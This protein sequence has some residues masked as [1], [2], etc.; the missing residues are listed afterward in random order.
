[1]SSGLP[2]DEVAE[3]YKSSLEDLVVN[4]RN[5]IGVLTVIAKENT[6]HAMAISRVL[7]NHI[8]TAPPARKL[9]AL[10]VL[11]SIV[12]NVGTPYTLYFQR[13]LYQ[14]FMG[15]YTLVDSNVRK[16]LDEMLKT[17]KEPVPGSLDTRPVFPPESTREIE[18][19]LIKARTAAIQQQARSQSAYPQMRNTNTP[20]N[21]WRNTPPPNSAS[22]MGQPIPGQVASSR[23][24]F[25]GYNSSGYPLQQYPT[26]QPSLQVQYQQPIPSVQQTPTPSSVDL[27]A[28]KQDVDNLVAAARTEFANNIS[29]TGVQQKLKALLDLKTLLDSRPLPEHQLRQIRDQ[30]SMMAPRQQPISRPTPPPMPMPIQS[31]VAPPVP[32]S[33]PSQQPTPQP[34]IPSFI[35]STNLAELLRATANRNQPTPPPQ[36]SS[37]SSALPQ[38][39]QTPPVKQSTPGPTAADNPIIAQLRA[40]GILTASSTPSAPSALPFTP[41]VP[42]QHQQLSFQQTPSTSLGS[43][44]L[45][46]ASIKISRLNLVTSLYEDRPNR[47]TTCGRRF[48]ADPEGKEKKS[49]HLDW[50]FKTNTRLAEAAKRGQS[51]SWYV[52]E[53]EW[54]SSRE[55]EDDSGPPDQPNGDNTASSAKKHEQFIL[56]P[57]DPI[58]RNAPCPI[59]QEKF[60]STWSEELQEFIWKDALKIN[61]RIYHATCYKEATKDKERGTTP[62]GAGRGR[63]ATPDSILGKRKAEDEMIGLSSKVK[64]EPI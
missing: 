29:N 38:I 19:A 59:C 26:P 8:R 10:Y 40:A 33:V 46:T 48:T 34:T 64:V 41:T 56:A 2:S 3:D 27:V 49:R 7:E 23:N 37:L 43:I 25:Q 60:E 35:N 42:V 44:K 12:K 53:R 58:L 55:Y 45:T 18:N 1:M 30:V 9:P 54:M 24:G 47:C 50:H 39:S 11:D 61:N 16:K 14:T 6:E 62:V 4:D 20:P 17:W 22:Q 15:A 13:N 52:D 5:Q 51:R 36:T 31:T 63:T 32:V 28:L 57:N 21:H